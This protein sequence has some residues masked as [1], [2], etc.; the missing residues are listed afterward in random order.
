M[1]IP[2]STLAIGALAVFIPIALNG[3][4]RSMPA[5]SAIDAKGVRHEC[6]SG[7]VGRI[8]WLNDVVRSVVPV[9]PVS[10]RINHHKGLVVL[11]ITLDSK[12]GSVTRTIVVASSGFPA[13]DQSAVAAFRQ[14]R[15]RPARWKEM[16]IPVSFE[17]GPWGMSY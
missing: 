17:F 10:E 13:L 4:Q 8:P 2:R 9:Y 1:R 11:R 3:Q 15:W 16:D 12:T 14:W 5:V 7:D 6:Q